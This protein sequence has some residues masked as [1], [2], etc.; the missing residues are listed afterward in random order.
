VVEFQQSP[1]LAKSSTAPTWRTLGSDISGAFAGCLIVF[2]SGST[3]RRRDL[4][5]YGVPLRILPGR[6]R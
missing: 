4:S 2:D 3:P 5:L 6:S 1:V